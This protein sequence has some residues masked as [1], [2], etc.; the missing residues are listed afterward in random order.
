MAIYAVV[1]GGQNIAQV[2]VLT[3]T[4]PV[5]VTVFV[6]AKNLNWTKLLSQM[7]FCSPQPFP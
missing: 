2:S 7:L 5:A 1:T 6:I 3:G 4:M